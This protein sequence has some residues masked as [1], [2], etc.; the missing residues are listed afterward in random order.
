MQ[1]VISL[2]PE[3]Y[4]AQV[5]RIWNHLEDR[6][7]LKYI[8]I[9]PIPH[10]TWQLGE[11][12]QEENV[13]S[14]LHELALRLEPFEVRTNGL[15]HF[16][17]ISPILFIEVRKS[18]KL[19]KLHTQ[20][21]NQLF[22]LTLEPSPL[23]SIETWHPHITLAMEDLGWEMLDEVTA[24]LQQTK[25]K[26]RFKLDNF[27]IACQHADGK[28]QVEHIFRFGKGLTESFDCGLPPL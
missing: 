24:M 27:A 22:P 25:M 15:N 4:N 9:T 6:F 8:R 12:Y 26:W 21:W 16:A 3:P 1:A 7:G 2:L 19:T 14:L 17:G 5:E 11:G 10:F 23:Y 20:I 18:V 28:A 13:L